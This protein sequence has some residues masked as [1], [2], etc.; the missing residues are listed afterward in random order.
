MSATLTDK[1]RWR[2]R[3]REL[4]REYQRRW[5][6]SPQGRAYMLPYVRHY[7]HQRR[8]LVKG[9]HGNSVYMRFCKGLWSIEQP[10]PLEMVEL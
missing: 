8:W 9:L 6:C 1:R 10:E 3:N 5:R 7:Q 2:E 4:C